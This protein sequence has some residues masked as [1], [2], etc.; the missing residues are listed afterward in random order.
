LCGKYR[1]T[2]L[3]REE[4]E[5]GLTPGHEY[6]V[7]DTRFG[8]IGMMICWDVYF[9]EVARRLANGGAELIL[10]PIW[11]GIDTLVQ[12]R[13][14]ENQVY[15]VTSTYNPKIRSAVFDRNGHAVVVATNDMPVAIAE[16]DL[17]ERNLDPRIGDWRAHFT[18]ERPPAD[19]ELLNRP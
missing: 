1:K 17:N 19:Y 8:K 15:I 6:P 9:P 2:C 13:A 12:A 16:I 5:G 7:F 10:A 14:I 3:P 11:G 4:I 18:R